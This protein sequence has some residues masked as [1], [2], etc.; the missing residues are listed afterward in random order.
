[1]SF[2]KNPPTSALAHS[3]QLLPFF[4]GIKKNLLW[5]SVFWNIINS[6]EQDW[7]L[8][9]TTCNKHPSSPTLKYTAITWMKYCRCGIKL[10]PINQSI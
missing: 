5:K 10:Y 2:H 6:K 9:K 8:Y 3:I 7:I 1:M 4:E